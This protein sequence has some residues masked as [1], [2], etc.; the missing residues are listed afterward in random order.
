M[1]T[2][3]TFTIYI[4]RKPLLEGQLCAMETRLHSG[5]GDLEHI[6]Q[7]FVRQPMKAMQDDRRALLVGQRLHRLTHDAR[8]VATLGQLFR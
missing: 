2:H 1:T 8:G 6:G 4:A 5:Q 7:L 3:F